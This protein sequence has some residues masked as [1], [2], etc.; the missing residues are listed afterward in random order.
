MNTRQDFH[1][2]DK[3]YLI[4]KTDRNSRSGMALCLNSNYRWNTIAIGEG[5][6]NYF[7]L[8]LFRSSYYKYS[9]LYHA[10]DYYH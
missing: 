8:R 3:C 1:N 4:F 5:N 10:R 2:T 7:P 6:N 9:D